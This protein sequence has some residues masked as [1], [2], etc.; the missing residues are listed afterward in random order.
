LCVPVRLFLARSRE[1]AAGREGS[2]K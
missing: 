2:D 1:P